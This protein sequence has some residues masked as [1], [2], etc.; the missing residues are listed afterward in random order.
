MFMILTTVKCVYRFFC[1]CFCRD[2]D[3]WAIVWNPERFVTLIT[4]RLGSLFDY[5]FLKKKFTLS[6]LNIL[7]FVCVLHPLISSKCLTTF[8]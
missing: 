3:V 7:L 6:T 8:I 5:L 4:A 1:V 2:L